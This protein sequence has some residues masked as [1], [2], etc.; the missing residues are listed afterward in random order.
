MAY[1]RFQNIFAESRFSLPFLMVVTLA[2]WVGRGMIEERLWMQTVCLGMSTYLMI[3]LNNAN[4]LLRVYSKMVSG[5]FLLLL[6]ATNPLYPDLR[7]SIITLCCVA[8]YTMLF[9]CYQQRKASG[10]VFYGFLCLGLASLVFIQILFF[11]PFLWGAMA[12]NLYTLN[13]KTFFASLLGL[14]TPYWFVGGYCIFMRDMTMLADHVAQISQ[15]A[16]LFDYSAVDEH[17]VVTFAFVALCAVTGIIHYLRNSYS[18]KIQTRMLY[19][20][21]ILI[22]VM[23]LIFIVLQPQHYVPLMAMLIV[24][25]APL[26]AHFV[27]LTHTWLTNIAFYLLLLLTLAIA[28]YNL[29]MPSLIF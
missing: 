13:A 5:C 14:F 21:F 11:I 16:P 2:A 1:K 12:F 4:Q 18:D 28:A 20:V 24:N 26:L 22:D 25:T 23:T 9:R 10:W 17:Q 6:T 7:M 19:E 8:L 3:E 15:F 29:W 27:T